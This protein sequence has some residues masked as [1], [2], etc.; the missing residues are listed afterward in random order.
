MP[1]LLQTLRSLLAA[2]TDMIELLSAADLAIE[3][4]LRVAR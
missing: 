3:G 4:D 1:C 2:L